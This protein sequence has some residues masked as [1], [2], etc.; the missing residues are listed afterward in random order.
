MARIG[1]IIRAVRT[2][3][4][5]AG[6]DIFTHHSIESWDRAI[7]AGGDNWAA[8]IV[9]DYFEMGETRAG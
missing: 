6:E 5:D 3:D 2:L 9:S 7:D 1:S 8:G 4:Q